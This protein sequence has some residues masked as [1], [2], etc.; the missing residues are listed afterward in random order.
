MTK[1]NR[2][3]VTVLLKKIIPVVVVATI[4]A[5]LVALRVAGKTVKQPAPASE[6]KGE[7]AVPNDTVRAVQE[8]LDKDGCKLKAEGRMGGQACLER[9]RISGE[10]NRL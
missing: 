4:S 8:A 5:L 3:G 2:K 10:G 9:V 6:I 7:K 1:S